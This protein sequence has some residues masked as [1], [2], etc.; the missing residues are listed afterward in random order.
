MQLQRA[1]GRGAPGPGPGPPAA[2]Y[3]TGWRR[4]RYI[5]VAGVTASGTVL[6]ASRA[7][8]R[9]MCVC[10]HVGQSGVFTCK[11]CGLGK[12]RVGQS[13]VILDCTHK[14]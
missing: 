12:S 3:R 6:V 9:Y 8:A 11:T 5:K 13:D 1:G 10:V 14:L 7:M 4:W 2:A